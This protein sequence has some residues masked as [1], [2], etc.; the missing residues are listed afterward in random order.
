[1]NIAIIGTGNVGRALGGS[2]LRAGHDVVLASHHPEG[3]RAA[4]DEIGARSAAVHEAAEGADLVALAVPYPAL[5]DVIAATGGAL[6]GKIIVDVTNPLTADYS[7]LALGDT[8]AAEQIRGKVAGGRVIK[9]FNSALAARQADPAVDGTPIDGFVAG[10]DEEAKT[11]VLDLVA[12]IGM[13]P[14]DAGPLAMARY[15]E[16]LAFLN[17]SLQMRHGWTWQSGWKL[18]GPT[19][20]S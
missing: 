8:S 3:A 10:D 1:M 9:A 13:R 15:L 17:I 16:A 11:K 12:A 20:A 5:D 18:I 4:A 19:S 14:I 2:F 6:D 7:G